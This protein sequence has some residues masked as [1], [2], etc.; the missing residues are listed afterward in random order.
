MPVADADID[1]YVPG[2]A[3]ERW[4]KLNALLKLLRTDYLS[5]SVT[6]NPASLADGAGE[7]SAGITVTGAA[8]G[9]F[10][11]VA[12]PY[13]L[14]GVLATAYVSAA[15]TVKIRLQNE[16]GGV[17]DLAEGSWKVRVYKD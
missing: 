14:Q 17:V 16:S 10:V 2:R 6:W 7:T 8:F 5:G 3:Q 12:A 11:V 9:D 4:W 13:D 15:D 1:S